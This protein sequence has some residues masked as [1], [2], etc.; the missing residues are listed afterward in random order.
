MTLTPVREEKPFKVDSDGISAPIA[1]GAQRCYQNL[2]EPGSSGWA[3]TFL[4]SL[5]PSDVLTVWSSSDP[6]LLSY[7]K[8]DGP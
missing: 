4:E 6:D 3:P 1:D 8:Q 7:H 2:S 5:Q